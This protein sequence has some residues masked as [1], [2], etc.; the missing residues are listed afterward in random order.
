MNKLSDE[1][2]RTAHYSIEFYNSDNARRVYH[3]ETDLFLQIKMSGFSAMRY[4][5]AE[6]NTVRIDLNDKI[7]SKTKNYVLATDIFQK[8]AEQL[9]DGKKL[10][11]IS[12]DTI[13]FNYN[14]RQSKRLPV[15]PNLNLT[16][17]SEYMQKG[18]T[19]ILP[20]SI[21]VSAEQ[22]ILNTLTQI[23]CISKKYENLNK[24]ING[25]LEIDVKKLANVSLSQR[26]VNFKVEVERYCEST[27]TVPLQM[28]NQP[29]N[30][31]VIIFP[32]EIEIKYRAGIANFTQIKPSDFAL[33]ADFN[34]FEKSVNGNLKVNIA[35]MPNS[36]LQVE[37]YP[38]FVELIVNK[39]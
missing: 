8:I 3:T 11:N 6:Q 29:A 36:I 17:A 35:A 1:Y 13:Y 23:P 38:E 12:P 15:V 30:L 7:I 25:E 27:I 32:R 9:G 20:D 31:N 4:K 10:I 19:V 16:F 34:D 39:K 22:N 26:K 18:N 33:N 14:D 28:L 24:S 21:L 2:L 5:Y 37:L